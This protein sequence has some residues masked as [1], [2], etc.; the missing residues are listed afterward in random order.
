MKEYKNRN[1]TATQTAVDGVSKGL[2]IPGK[3]EWTSEEVTE[4]PG[5]IRVSISV[6]HSEDYGRN[7]FNVTVDH[8]LSCGQSPDEKRAAYT[9][10]K[11]FCMSQVKELREEVIATLFS[12]NDL[13]S[14]K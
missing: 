7:K 13:R 8:A 10:A 11:S 1:R 3:N 14:A 2:P 4:G 9:E 12:A 5:S 6:G